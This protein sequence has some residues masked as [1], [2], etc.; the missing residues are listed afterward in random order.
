M[1]SNNSVPAP[2][3]V[4]PPLPSIPS[5]EKKVGFARPTLIIPPPRTS[6]NS[7]RVFLNVPEDGPKRKPSLMFDHINQLRDLGLS[8][9]KTS[10]GASER[11]AY[12]LYSKVKALSKKWFTHCFLTIVLLIYT[13]G[14]ALSFKAIEENKKEETGE[15]QGESKDAKGSKENIEKE[16][17]VVN[18]DSN[19]TGNEKKNTEDKKIEAGGNNAAFQEEKNKETEELKDKQNNEIG[20]T[21]DEA[22]VGKINENKKVETTEEKTENAKKKVEQHNST[23]N[24]EVLPLPNASKDDGEVCIEKVDEKRNLLCD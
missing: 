20:E 5:V 18:D 6:Q 3:D 4:T 8:T 17:N 10:L 2:P 7:P 15:V 21:A 22:T 14:G 12:W 11:C 19:S 23:E 9:A 24:G 13:V 16:T 1:E